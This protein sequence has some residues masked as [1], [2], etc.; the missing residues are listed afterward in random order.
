MPA[1]RSRP[2]PPWRRRGCAASSSLLRGSRGRHLDLLA[3]ALADARPPAVLALELAVPHAGRPIAPG[4]DHLHVADGKRDRQVDDA[5]LLRPRPRLLVALGHVDSGDHDAEASLRLLDPVDGA[6][7]AAVLAGQD[8]DGVT[9]AH[10]HLENLRRERH[11]L[12]VVA[13]A[14]LTGHRP[15]DA[16]AARAALGIDEHGRVLVESDVAAVGPPELLRRADDHGAN[17]LALLHS[18]VRQRLLDGSHDD[19]ADFGGVARG[20]PDD[21]DALHHTGAGVVGHAK[22]AVLLDHAGSEVSIISSCEPRA[23]TSTTVQRFSRES[24]RLSSMR[25]VSPTRAVFSASCALNLLERRT[26]RL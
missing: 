18:G 14:Q 10:V 3:T 25:T 26:T 19:V 13:L 11:D 2:S 4:A 1:S 16:G 20:A 6:A 24:G 21:R 15:E 8:Q 9:P 12:H 5:C 7:L 17:H 23:T 22:P